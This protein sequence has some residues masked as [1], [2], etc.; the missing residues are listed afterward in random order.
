MC[1]NI[2][3]HPQR[4]MQDSHALLHGWSCTHS[5]SHTLIC[6]HWYTCVPTCTTH[7]AT[8]TISHPQTQ[9]VHTGGHASPT[10][11]PRSPCALVHT[12][13]GQL[14][15]GDVWEVVSRTL[16]TKT[17]LLS[18]FCV[19]LFSFWALSEGF[20]LLPAHSTPSLACLPSHS[21]HPALGCRCEAGADGR[22]RHSQARI[23]PTAELFTTPHPLVII[24]FSY[25][26]I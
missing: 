9:P 20:C 19:W 1:M 2:H 10:H 3:N 15:S 4:A 13:P 12:Q 16:R 24:V 6:R 8:H 23:G 26:S 11:S 5:H 7:S 17:T 18:S 22:E 14:V 21:V 25:I